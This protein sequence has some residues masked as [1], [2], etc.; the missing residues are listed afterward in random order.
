[1]GA[2]MKQHHW[3]PAALSEKLEADGAPLRIRLLGENYV[4]F[5]ATDGRVGFFD[6]ACPHRGASLALA[7]NED[8]ALRC[9]YHGWKFDVGGTTVAVPT[10]VQNVREFCD[11]VPLAHYP[12]REAA[13]IVWVWLGSGAH[14]PQFPD[15]EFTALPPEHRVVHKQVGHFNW[16][17]A[18]ETTMDS[19]H[20]GVLH[21][22]HV[23]SMGTLALAA[24]NQAPVYEIET[25][26][27][28]FRY[29]GIRALADGSR[30][31]RINS[32][33][34]PWYGII[35]PRQSPYA[36]GA[37]FFVIPIDNEHSTYW[38]VRYRV[39]APIEKDAVTLFSDAADWPPAVPG[40]AENNWGQDRSLM[41]QG[42]FTGFP[43]HL[44]TEDLVIVTSQGPIVDR[45]KEYLNSGDGALVRLRRVLLQALG[46]F[47]DE[48]S[49]A[50]DS[51][52]KVEY[53]ALR[54][55]AG[56]VPAGEDWRTIAR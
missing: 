23:A 33:V 7:R 49:R 54:G 24:D 36:G 17:Q 8:N 45:T 53:H 32:F 6:E 20:A 39:D 43:Q 11:S 42:H 12:A 2:M 46:E 27:H 15:F 52:G 55:V 44:T 19:A 4:A 50:E 3:M 1:M 22:S 9:I 28:G 38:T 30:Y 41:R 34:L 56:V 31:V 18:V 16:L 13:G 35:A 14:A 21:Q 26:P 5:R 10:Q 48:D 25:R 37:V 47:M 40:T 29:A 51:R